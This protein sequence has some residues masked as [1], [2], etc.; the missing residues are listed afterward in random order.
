LDSSAVDLRLTPDLI[1]VI[2]QFLGI[3]IDVT[4]LHLLPLLRLSAWK[5]RL[6]A[7]V[8]AGSICTGQVTSDNFR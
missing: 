6:P 3:G 5:V 8:R 1:L 2:D 4:A 7:D